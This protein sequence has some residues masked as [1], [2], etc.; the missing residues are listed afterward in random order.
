MWCFSH[1]KTH[2]SQVQSL[3]VN[4]RKSW[5]TVVL[6]GVDETSPCESL[7]NFTALVLILECVAFGLIRHTIG[8]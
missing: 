5:K 8:H 3:F 6:S 1:S 7:L 4:V 2:I